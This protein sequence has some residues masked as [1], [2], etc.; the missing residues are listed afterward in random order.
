M[1]AGMQP[2]EIGL[3][4]LAS[5]YPFPVDDAGPDLE[6]QEGFDY[7]RILAGPV[8]TPASV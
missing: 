1:D 8:I 7:P 3:P 4:I 6:G 5:P 2:V